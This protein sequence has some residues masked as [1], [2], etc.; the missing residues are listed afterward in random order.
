MNLKDIDLNLLVIFNE[1]LLEKRVAAVAEKLDMAQPSVS[2]ALARLRRLLDDE[3]FFR[4]PRGME[5]TSY[6]LQIAEPI[7]Y[8]LSTIRSTL[9]Q[10]NTFDPGTSK[11]RFTIGMTDIGEIYFLPRLMDILAR[12]APQVTISTVRNTAV[13][14]RD[15]M[16]AGHVDVAIGLLPQ[17]KAGF[18]QRRLFL[19]R[20]VCM[21]RKGHALD[22]SKISLKE[23]SQ[24]EHVMVISSGTGHAKV[25][26]ILEKKGI[27]RRVRLAVPHFVAVGHLLATTDMVATV[28]ERYA[29]EC[30][31]PFSLRFAK[32]PVA[33]PD[34]GINIFWHAKAHREPENQWLR[35]LIV[36]EF[37]DSQEAAMP[38]NSKEFDQG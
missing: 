34:V 25:D 24:A 19:Q 4:T 35:N 27:A 32:H 26:E 33:L 30:A 37:A 29:Q 2:N 20:Y 28:P 9:N 21:F 6:A 7:S 11:R 13:N 16:E 1:L 38:G 17:L 14:L 22:K 18:F 5:P 10:Q 36:A 3:L 8:A 23:F 31:I 15:E 12:V